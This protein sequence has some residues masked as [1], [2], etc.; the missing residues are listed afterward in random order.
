VVAALLAL[1]ALATPA[2]APPAVTRA[3][4]ATPAGG[5]RAVAATAPL[6]GLPYVADPLG[7]EEGPDADP[8]FRL[9]AFDCLTF[10]ETAVALGSAGTL[11]DARRALEDVRYDGDPALASRHHEVLSQWIPANLARGWVRD[12]AAEVAPGLVRRE[13]KAYTPA[14]WAQVRRAGRAIPGLPRE[15][16]P[17]GTFGVDAV[18]A[19]VLLD[20]AERIPAGTLA[21]VLRADAPDRATR[22]SH[23]GLV[24]D[25]GGGKWVR[26]AT[27][28]V[29]VGRVIEEPLARFLV[30]NRRSRPAWPV[31]GVAL[32]EIRDNR[33][34]L[35]GSLAGL[36]S[37]G[38]PGAVVGTH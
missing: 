8:R 14:S 4:A 28:T 37:P 13:E 30:R 21:F 29:G 12:V 20:V 17:L 16:L 1:A 32:L 3:L 6:R 7:E 27:S 31:T 22:V 25:R 11:A 33:S 23:V 24:F 26:H 2:P 36:S 9:D 19:D 5:L 10:V 34:H 15:R 38:M 35:A 18:P